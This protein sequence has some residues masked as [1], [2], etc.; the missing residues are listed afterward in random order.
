M[1]RVAHTGIG[2]ALVFDLHGSLLAGGAHRHGDL[3]VLAIGFHL[4]KEF[5][6]FLVAGRNA[7]L[8]QRGLCIGRGKFERVA[9]QVIAIGNIK[10]QR[11]LAI[12]NRFDL[13]LKGV[14]YRQQFVLVH[15]GLSRLTQGYQQPGCKQQP[16][17][18]KATRAVKVMTVIFSREFIPHCH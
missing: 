10:A 9:I 14:V 17:P 1:R 5:I 12:L 7:G 13:N 2:T 16:W 8:A 4:A 6:L 15:F 18:G 11:G 3:K